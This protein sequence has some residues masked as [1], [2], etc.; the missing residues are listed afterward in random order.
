MAT[1]EKPADSSLLQAVL[2]ETG[3]NASLC[4]FC[5]KCTSGCPLSH[6]MD[7][8]PHQVMRSI[9]LDRRDAVLKSKTIWVCASCQTCVTR[10]PNEI[11]I[12]RVMDCLRQMAFREKLLGK[13]TVIPA[14]HRIFLKSIRQRGRQYELGMLL[15]LKLRVRD[16]FGDIGIGIKMLRKRK[17]SLLPK[18]L[19]GYREIKSIFSKIEEGRD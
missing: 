18:R 16:L 2:E 17:L 9:Q 15:E 3:E 13:E 19:K 6:H 5:K 4:Y 1:T 8:A 11:D 12:P 14:F 7:V 10:C